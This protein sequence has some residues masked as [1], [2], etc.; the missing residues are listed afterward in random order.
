MI[1]YILVGFKILIL[2]SFLIQKYKMNKLLYPNIESIP[3]RKDFVSQAINELINQDINNKKPLYFYPIDIVDKD[4]I[5]YIDKNRVNIYRI[6]CFGILPSGSKACVIIK[7]VP[8]NLYIKL[9][10]NSLNK[11]DIDEEKSLIMSQI[12][13]KCFAISELIKGYP[14]MEFSIDEKNYLRVYFNNLKDR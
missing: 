2:Y 3:T 14:L 13:K 4:D 12:H 9:K 1:Y 5:E 10:C 6:Y 8:I 11:S 7:D